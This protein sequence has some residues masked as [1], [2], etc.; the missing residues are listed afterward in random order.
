M[1]KEQILKKAIEKYNIYPNGDI[2][3]KK[4]GKKLVPHYDGI[5]YPYISIYMGNGITKKINVHRL[6]AHVFLPLPSEKSFTQINHKNGDH[7]DNRVEN[8]E[9]CSP[10][11][12]VSDGF[13]RG[14]IIWNK[15]NASK[16]R[17]YGYCKKYPRQIFWILT[18]NDFYF[19]KAFFGEKELEIERY[20]KSSDDNI[21]RLLE[22]HVR[23]IKKIPA[24]QYHL[25]QMVLEEDP[26]KYLERFL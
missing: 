6:V 12:N 25:Q 21:N 5:R 3:S 13:K 24:W 22:Y 7:T 1:N 2:V 15:G 8:L 17:I 18:N 26:I 14:R 19:A 10:A 9:W 20:V 4:S 16:E 11:Y 23:R